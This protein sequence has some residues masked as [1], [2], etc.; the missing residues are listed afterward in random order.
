[1]VRPIKLYFILKEIIKTILFMKGDASEQCEKMWESSDPSI[2][3]I[4]PGDN[5]IKNF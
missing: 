1:M 2:A 3:N 4:C 5:K